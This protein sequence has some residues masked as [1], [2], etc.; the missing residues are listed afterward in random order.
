MAYYPPLT[1]GLPAK[2]LNRLTNSISI[3]ERLGDLKEELPYKQ[4]RRQKF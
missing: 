1:M 2:E 3:W 4:E